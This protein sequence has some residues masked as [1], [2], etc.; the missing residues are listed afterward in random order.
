MKLAQDIV[1]DVCTAHGVLISQ[2][3]GNETLREYVRCRKAV[4]Q[5]L[6]AEGYCPAEIGRAI[7]CSRTNVYNLL[8]KRAAHTNLNRTQEQGR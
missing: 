7:H 4:A 2:L 3:R 5:A 1:Q 8:G 6:Y